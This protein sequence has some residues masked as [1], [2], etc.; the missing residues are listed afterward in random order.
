MLD[1]NFV[2]NNGL[3]KQSVS[4]FFFAFHLSRGNRRG[5]QES[6]YNPRAG[7]LFGVNSA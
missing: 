5:L 3:S 7:F 2:K 6:V 1:N 4:P